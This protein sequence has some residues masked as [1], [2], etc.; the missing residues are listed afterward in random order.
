MVA[1]RNGLA[2][3]LTLAADAVVCCVMPAD[4]PP[5]TMTVATMHTMDGT[6]RDT[7]RP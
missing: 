3:S 4:S 7:K 2:T 1:D 6:G 5:A